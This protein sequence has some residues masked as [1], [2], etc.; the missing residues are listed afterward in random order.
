MK[1]Y[2]EKGDN[3]TVPSPIVTVGGAGVQIGN[4]FGIA[5]GIAQ[6]GDPL[7]LS[8]VGVFAIE[9]VTADDVALGDSIFWDDTARKATVTATDNLKIGVAV[10]GK[11]GTGDVNVRLNGSF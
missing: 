6:V 9:K 8:T 3:I 5:N 4:L 11:S 7:V 10:E 1:N 2:I